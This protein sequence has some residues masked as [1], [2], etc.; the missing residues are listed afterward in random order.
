VLLVDDGPAMRIVCRL[1]L[2]LDGFD[3]V[4]DVRTRRR[5][6]LT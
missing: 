5:A 2:E 6:T 1:N 4:E 3:V